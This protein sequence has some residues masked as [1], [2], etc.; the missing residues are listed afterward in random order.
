MPELIITAPNGVVWKRLPGGTT[1]GTDF[2]AALEM[3]VSLSDV[4]R[5]WNWWQEG[6]ER[7]ER[8]RLHRILEQ[9][10]HAAPPPGGYLS[11]EEL[12]AEFAAKRAQR[13]E[14]RQRRAASYDEERA[15]IRL[16]LLRAEATAGFMC[17]ALAIP[18]SRAW[19]PKA[20]ELRRASEREAAALKEKLGDPNAV[21]DQAGDLPQTRR[22]RHLY[23]HM[24]FFRHP[25]LQEWS[26]SQR[27]RFHKLLAM[28]PPRPS[29]MCA[30][31]QAPADWH[32]YGFSLS[33][34]QG[35]P[36]SGSTAEV[37][38]R[39]MPGWWERCLAC[40]PYQL[41][42]QWG[43]N[44]LPDFGYEQWHA[45]LPPL[46][47]AIFAPGTPAPRKPVDPRAALEKRLRATEAK[48]EQ[49][50]RQLAEIELADRG[51]QADP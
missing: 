32:T 39:L 28:P 51:D 41:H 6:R 42:H 26:S 20:E 22:E 13:E 3:L 14:E 45:M 30:E 34:W 31:C 29:D 40:T 10:D 36:A 46:L 7:R 49:L 17:N 15:M 37:L 33:L 4:S 5:Q 25:L 35:K 21:V 11:K 19:Q 8:E 12:D 27:K 38:G 48:A 16:S 2:L 24:A 47:R 44:A 23:E 9:W 1:S 43:H 18:G 50:R